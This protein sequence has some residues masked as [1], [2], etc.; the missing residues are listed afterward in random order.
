MKKLDV[1]LRY[2]LII[3]DW[4]GTLVNSTERIIDSMQ[5]A[6]KFLEMPE[7]E[8]IAVQHI[9]GLGLPEAIRTLWPDADDAQVAEI[10]PQYAR[11]FVSDSTVEMSMFDGAYDM[12]EELLR[13]GHILAVAT[14]KTRKG[15][16]RMMRDLKLGHLFAVTRCADETRSKPHPQM[17]HEIL[18]ELGVAPH[19]ALM[20]GD[21][22]FD[23]D[24]AAAAGVSS[25]AMS[26]GAHD[27]EKLMASKPLA[28]CHNIN[29]LR[30]W[31]LTH[32]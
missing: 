15:L 11:F 12:L 4:D 9:I 20:V 6:G 2:K 8:D 21:T 18:S 22:T 16:D 28:V 14:G 10:A 23:L 26:H 7:L 5:Q 3:F 24:M 17:L 27:V 13:Q 19:E 25:I 30:D 1:R 32:G 31:I 29:Q